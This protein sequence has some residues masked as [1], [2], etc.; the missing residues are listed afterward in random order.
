MKKK[1]FQEFKVNCSKITWLKL[2]EGLK[3][4]VMVLA[5]SVAAGSLISFADFLG[6]CGV[7][8]FV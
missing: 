8:L 2:P 5:V 7:S 3:T 4:T 1:E 6:K